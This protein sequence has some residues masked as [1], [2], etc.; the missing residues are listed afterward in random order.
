MGLGLELSKYYRLSDLFR[1][2]KLDEF[3]ILQFIES[4]FELDQGKRFMNSFCQR[5]GLGDKIIS[6]SRS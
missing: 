4:L 2:S 3:Q 6:T 5:I 1:K